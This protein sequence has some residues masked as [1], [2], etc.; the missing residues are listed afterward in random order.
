M[1]KAKNVVGRMATLRQKHRA[2]Q[3]EEEVA[4]VREAMVRADWNSV[5]AA[6]WLGMPVSSVTGF[7]YRCPELEAEWKAGRERREAA[8]AEGRIAAAQKDLERLRKG[9]PSDGSGRRL[10]KQRWRADR[11]EAG[12]PVS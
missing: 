1:G 4:L 8:V 12:L 6:E 11:R 2:R 7:L 3:R 5:E 10:Y 9:K